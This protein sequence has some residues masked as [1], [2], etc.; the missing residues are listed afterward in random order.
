MRENLH[1]GFDEAG[2]VNQFTVWLFEALSEETER[3]R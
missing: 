2:T 3:N 1:A